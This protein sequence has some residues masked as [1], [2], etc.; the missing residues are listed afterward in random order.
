M[1]IPPGVSYIE[2]IWKYFSPGRSPFYAIIVFATYSLCW[3]QHLLLS[4]DHPI[5][6]EQFYAFLIPIAVVTAIGLLISTANNFEL[7]KHEHDE[8]ILFVR[9]FC[10]SV[11]LVCMIW[12]GDKFTY[13]S[14]Q[15]KLSYWSCIAQIVIF[16][17][18]AMLRLKREQPPKH[19]NLIQLGLITATFMIGFSYCLQ[20]DV[21]ASRTTIASQ[22]FLWSMPAGFWALYAGWLVCIY[23]WIRH[24]LGIISIKVAEEPPLQPSP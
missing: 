18:Y 7:P 9:S 16:L 1:I 21:P 17:L 10:I 23:N 14:G 11:A 3:A 15:A 2:T 8:Q 13:G 5:S 19:S 4:Q 6:P 22:T 12:T 24:L 20:E